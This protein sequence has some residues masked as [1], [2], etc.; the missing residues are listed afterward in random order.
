[1]GPSVTPSLANFAGHTPDLTNDNNMGR[2]ASI[3]YS[4]VAQ[5][6]LSSKQGQLR[7]ASKERKSSGRCSL[8][9]LGCI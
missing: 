1:M 9:V 8:S 2:E 4:L 7:I 3:N 5:T 6:R